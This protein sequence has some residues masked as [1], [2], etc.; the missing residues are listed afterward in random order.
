MGNECCIARWVMDGDQ[1]LA[2][3]LGGG[4][5]G[6]LGNRARGAQALTE[7]RVVFTPRRV[8]VGRVTDEVEG[9]ARQ[10]RRTGVLARPE[11]AVRRTAALGTT[12]VRCAATAAIFLLRRKAAAY[13]SRS[14]KSGRPDQEPSPPLPLTDHSIAKGLTKTL[15]HHIDGLTEKGIR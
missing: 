1:L 6:Q 14:Q 13:A 4:G 9:D 11:A 7:A 15:P 10:P 3:N 5:G 12:I 8:R 2:S